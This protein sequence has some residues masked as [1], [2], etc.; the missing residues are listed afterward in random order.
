[1]R[2]TIGAAIVIILL[3]F[4]W[5]ILQ[6]DGDEVTVSDFGVVKVN[7][8]KA[9]PAESQINTAAPAECRLPEN[10]LEAWGKTEKWTADSGWR[11]GGSSPSQFCG[12][13]K[14]A[15]EKQ[16]PDRKVDL[17]STDEKHKSEYTPFKHDFYRY[18]CL[19]EDRWAPIY[20]LAENPNC[21]P[22]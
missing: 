1:M 12:A 2:N 5:R 8:K 11:R 3:A 13:Q 18:T 20:K 21:A 16:F 22:R 19:F 7:P 4:A 9:A 10:G 17:I 14:L 6:G 15:R